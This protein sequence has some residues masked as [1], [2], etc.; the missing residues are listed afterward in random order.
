MQVEN[1]DN[2]TSING[3][4]FTPREI[5]IIS[6]IISGRNVKSI[7]QL[8]NISTRTTESHIQSIKQKFECNSKDL[9]ARI[10]EKSPE[11][12]SLIEHYQ[13]IYKH[14]L[15]NEIIKKIKPIIEAEKVFVTHNLPETDTYQKFITLLKECGIRI[16][17]DTSTKELHI[18]VNRTNVIQIQDSNEIFL[19]CSVIGVFCK[20][21]DVLMLVEKL[22]NKNTKTEN[23]VEKKSGSLKYIIIL[24]LVITC[25]FGAKFYFDKKDI[26]M[27]NMYYASDNMIVRASLLRRIEQSVENNKNAIKVIV[28]TGRGGAGKTMIARN[29]VEDRSANIKWEINAESKQT[30]INSFDDFAAVFADKHSK[31][32]ELSS[33]RS[34]SNPDVRNK[35][36]M[37]FVQSCLKEDSNWY[38]LFDNIDDLEIVKEYFPLNSGIWGRGIVLIT[39]RNKNIGKNDLFSCR[40]SQ[41]G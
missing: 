14:E 10:T 41:C 33:I 24:F 31:Q 27:S 13:N 15:L 26:I 32:E 3:I 20:D 30:I 40:A 37:S 17:R 25:A 12:D 29:F 34:I 28:I 1:K 5:D 11:Y 23:N 8:F 6:C 19:L 16:D 18:N 22:Q 7:S 9:I 21:N 2:I 4:K 38:L 36:I 35:K 39:T